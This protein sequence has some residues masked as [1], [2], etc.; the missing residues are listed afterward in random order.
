MPMQQDQRKRYD[1]RWHIERG[2][3]LA[4]ILTLLLQTAGVVWWASSITAQVNTLQEQRVA[5]KVDQA[6]VD[7]RQDDDRERAE[8]R[9]LAQLDLLNKKVDALLAQRGD[10]R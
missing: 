9:M 3:P 5:A 1:D 2:V 7:R 8:Q 10:R 6:A 4:I